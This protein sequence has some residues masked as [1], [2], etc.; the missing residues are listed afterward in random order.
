MDYRIF[1]PDE[2]IDAR[3]ALPVSKSMMNRALVINA[4]TPGATP[5]IVSEDVADDITVMARAIEA[6]RG[7][8]PG[9]QTAVNVGG[10]GSAMRFLAAM[11]SAT[12]GAEVSLDGDVRIFNMLRHG[13]SPT[14]TFHLARKAF[15]DAYDDATILKWMRTFYRRF[16]S[17]QFKRSCMPDGPKV[18][19]V[20]LSPRGDWRMPSDAS[21]A[22]YL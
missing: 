17:Q 22:D 12:E 7:G 18:G 3:V 5:M 19:S 11:I 13:F 1:P 16:F 9:T 21:V 8:A 15:R 14:K 4:L 2:P 10:S 6:I 20:S